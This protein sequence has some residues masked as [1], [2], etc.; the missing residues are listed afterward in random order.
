MGALARNKES[1]LSSFKYWTLLFCRFRQQS[2]APSALNGGPIVGVFCTGK[3]QSLQDHTF[4][5][6]RWPCEQRTQ[7]LILVQVS[8]LEII[9]LCPAG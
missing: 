9:P 1:G 2:G 6:P 3:Q 5:V 4:L 8:L 7:V